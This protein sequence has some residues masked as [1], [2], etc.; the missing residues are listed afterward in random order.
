MHILDLKVPKYISS[1]LHDSKTP[2]NIKTIRGKGILETKSNYNFE[3]KIILKFEVNE[4]GLIELIKLQARY[5]S[6]MILPIFD[7]EISLK[8]LDGYKMYKKLLDNT[9]N[10]NLDSEIDNSSYK[11]REKNTEIFIKEMAKLGYIDIP[12]HSDCFFSFLESF[13]YKTIPNSTEGYEVDIILWSCTDLS[14][15]NDDR[16]D[17]ILKFYQNYE[18]KKSTFEKIDEYIENLFKNK[19]DSIHIEFKNMYNEQD[20]YTDGKSVDKEETPYNIFIPGEF[21]TDVEVRSYNNLKRVPIQ[22]KPKGFIQHLGKGEIAISLRLVFNEINARN[23][24]VIHKL[25]TLTLTEQKYITTTDS[26]LYL[27]KAL[28]V[29][30]IDLVNVSVTEATDELD[31]TII[32]MLFIA[33]CT[34]KIEANS[35]YLNPLSRE[36]TTVYFEGIENMFDKA[37]ESYSEFK[38]LLIQSSDVTN[39]SNGV[40]KDNNFNLINLVNTY[41]DENLNKLINKEKIAGND[42]LNFDESVLPVFDFLTTDRIRRDIYGM[43]A[44][45]YRFNQFSYY[46]LKNII[47]SKVNEKNLYKVDSEAIKNAIQKDIETKESFIDDIY[48]YFLGYQFNMKTDMPHMD[49][50]IVNY[51]IQLEIINNLLLYI[52]EII[53]LSYSDEELVGILSGNKFTNTFI[54]ENGEFNSKIKKLIDKSINLVFRKTR[55]IITSEEFKHKAITFYGMNLFNGDILAD[56]YSTISKSVEGSISKILERYDKVYDKNSET[57]DSN[58]SRI[59][60]SIFKLCV[61]GNS[62]IN[63]TNKNN[64]GTDGLHSTI[65]AS[66]T[67]EFNIELQSFLIS[68]CIS[69][70]YIPNLAFEKADLG[71]V[72]RESAHSLIGPISISAIALQEELNR[73]LLQK[74][75]TSENEISI[76]KEKIMKIEDIK[77]NINELFGEGYFDKLLNFSSAFKRVNGQNKDFQSI[78]GIKIFSDYETPLDFFDNIIKSTTVSKKTSESINRIL[79]KTNIKQDDYGK[80]GK[81]I[82]EDKSVKEIIDNLDENQ[83]SIYNETINAKIPGNSNPA[84]FM[85]KMLIGQTKMYRSFKEITRIISSDYRNMMPDFEVLLI[86]ESKVEQALYESSYRNISDYFDISNIY[87]ISIK[88]DDT[89]NIKNAIIKIANTRPYYVDANSYFKEI[90]FMN[91]DISDTVLYNKKFVTNRPEIREGMVINI[92]LDKNNDYYDF[93]GRINS[94]D[95]NSGEVTISCVSFASELFNNITDVN[96][97]KK[98]GKLGKISFNSFVS[99][100]SSKFDNAKE[101]AA[102]KTYR[103]P[104]SNLI[105]KDEI[106]VNLNDKREFNVA[107]TNAILYTA[108]GDVL[109]SVNHLNCSYNQLIF[110]EKTLSKT[111]KYLRNFNFRDV[112]KNFIS[113]KEIAKN[114]PNRIAENITNTDRDICFYGISVKDVDFYENSNPYGTISTNKKT[115][116]NTS[117]FIIGDEMENIG[118]DIFAYQ[119]KNASLYDILNDVTL[120]S[121]GTFWEVYESGNFATLFFGRNNYQLKRKNKTSSLNIEEINSI[122]KYLLD[123]IE[124]NGEHGPESYY[125]F[126]NTLRSAAKI[127][128]NTIDSEDEYIQKLEK[129]TENI[130]IP[131]YDDISNKVY[132]IAGFNLISCNIQVNKTCPNVIKFEYD[133]TLS[134]KIKE[135][136]KFTDG[137]SIELKLFENIPE[138]EKRVKYVDYKQIPCVHT[139]KQAYE[140]AQSIMHNELRNYYSGKIV[141]LYNSNIRKNT[142]VTIMDTRNKIFGTVVVKDYQH[143]L[144]SEMG[145]VTI[146][147]PGMKTRSTSLMSDVYLCGIWQKINYALLRDEFI[148]NVKYKEELVGNITAKSLKDNFLEAMKH[149]EDIP[150]I[151]NNVGYDFD[152]NS[153]NENDNSY[154]AEVRGTRNASELPFKI[155]PLIKNGIPIMP[156]STIFGSASTPFYWITNIMLSFRYK[157]VD[158]ILKEEA[159]NFILENIKDAFSDKF[160][161]SD[162]KGIERIIKLFSAFDNPNFMNEIMREDYEELLSKGIEDNTLIKYDGDL[163]A[164]LCYGFLNCA[165]LNKLETERIKRIAKIMFHFEIVNLVELDGRDILDPKSKSDFSF[166]I[167][168]DLKEQLEYF[169]KLYNKPI[170]EWTIICKD[171]LIDGE[172]YKIDENNWYDDIGAVIV[173][174]PEKLALKAFTNKGTIKYSASVGVEGKEKTSVRRGLRY[175]HNLIDSKGNYNYGKSS[176]DICVIHNY[177]GGTIDSYELRKRMLDDLINKFFDNTNREKIIFGD[178]NLHLRTG[179]NIYTEANNKNENYDIPNYTPLIYKGYTTA[180]KKLYDNIVVDNLSIGGLSTVFRY[181][182]SSSEEYFKT[183]SELFVSDHFP[184]FLVINDNY[185]K[186]VFKGVI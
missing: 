100:V 184:I 161:L 73:L 6:L 185:K 5:Q 186:D 152:V 90:G 28:D 98:S 82:L 88:K 171:R 149:L 163:A 79:E 104:N 97:Y 68:Y 20:T 56:H 120:R 134:R 181:F 95:I 45:L 10:E 103:D 183:G 23:T 168:N 83:K 150:I 116:F 159:R 69:S 109:S 39:E 86:D 18:I 24:E 175:T 136:F 19:K 169:S 110:N 167:V 135:W 129:F 107:G 145:L 16:E 114:T 180:G 51:M 78:Y 21:I 11:K 81:D 42:R 118:S 92:S 32:N 70:L 57:V 47:V 29:K 60:T 138:S 112:I 144:D 154:E 113:G 117:S 77:R 132:A 71:L 142:E 151:M 1:L 72:L 101:I 108:L 160:N 25:K 176:S 177:Y 128:D 153:S 155:Y 137:K 61:M 85:S 139:P 125:V 67:N 50:T 62:N 44:V 54:L 55:E 124:I 59:I 130:S 106:A 58:Y 49:L 157:F 178:F 143:I 162:Y 14:Y 52:N 4:K 99:E 173:N 91:D 43:D 36:S 148:S 93:T 127:Y 126:Y 80:Y 15:L 122:F 37:I 147:T 105:P 94:V 165:K 34:N 41:Y 33:S 156:D 123:T 121:P 7:R 166:D 76:D 133:S 35:D 119:R 75:I 172:P 26:D 2:N 40:E 146:I 46:F 141:M 96:N 179:L 140:V 115:V 182:N 164:K 64:F 102:S 111:E 53:E 22:N 131:E 31:A 170:K 84:Y 38:G 87:H 9:F 12:E 8:I 30:E 65:N 48:E 63:N 74:V 17:F 66:F 27:I 3:E 13:S 174:L 89:T 158:S